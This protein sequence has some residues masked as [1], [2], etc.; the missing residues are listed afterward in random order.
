MIDEL[1][2]FIRLVAFYD[3]P[4]AGEARWSAKEFLIR[5]YQVWYHLVQTQSTDRAESYP[6][7]QIDNLTA[8]PIHSSQYHP[9]GLLRCCK[10][11]LDTSPHKRFDA[12]WENRR[13]GSCSGSHVRTAACN[14]LISDI[15]IF[16]G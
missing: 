10:I 4:Q 2:T 3:H 11:G 16:P 13:L 12:D 8:E 5:V 1:L 6:Q 15:P 7:A 9:R 14:A